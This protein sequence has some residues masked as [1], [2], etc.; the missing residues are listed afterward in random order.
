MPLRSASGQELLFDHIINPSFGPQ[1]IRGNSALK[2]YP[3]VMLT[4]KTFLFLLTFHLLTG[5][6]NAFD[7]SNEFDS[8][9]KDQALR[10]EFVKFINSVKVEEIC[11]KSKHC[12][13][14]I[15]FFRKDDKYMV[16]LSAN[17]F[18][19]V[20][21][22]GAISTE[23]GFVYLDSKYIIVDGKGFS[24]MDEFINLEV[25]NPAIPKKLSMGDE[26]KPVTYTY[27]LFK[28]E[29]TGLVEQK[30]NNP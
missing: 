4:A 17:Q 8:L 23:L 7:Q 19:S 30:S 13:L 18:K 14:E 6:E 11:S 16:G 25:L 28:I 3:T 9:I 26:L 2:L 22:P 29:G 12:V 1:R 15:S 24:E 5:C 20:T 27:K 21:P 10:V